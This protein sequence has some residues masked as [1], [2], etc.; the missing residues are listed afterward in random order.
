MQSM[1]CT[2]S[3]SHIYSSITGFFL[4]KSQP[5]SNRGE[6]G[7][8]TNISGHFFSSAACSCTPTL[9]RVSVVAHKLETS[10]DSCLPSTV[11][12]QLANPSLVAA[13]ALVKGVC[14]GPEY[15]QVKEVLFLVL[16]KVFKGKTCSKCLTH[17]L[18]WD[19]Q[20]GRLTVVVAAQSSFQKIFKRC[21]DFVI[22][23]PVE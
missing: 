23:C 2:L 18:S 10:L 20:S 1:I 8:G 16:F 22:G 13:A 11:L 4:W 12:L 3:H 14:E 15:K 6:S 9:C 5:S 21:Q 7:Q 17:W 19:H